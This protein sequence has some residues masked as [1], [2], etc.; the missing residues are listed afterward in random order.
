MLEF[1]SVLRVSVAVLLLRKK[2][3]IVVVQSA[4]LVNL[5]SMVVVLTGGMGCGKSTAGRMFEKRGFRRLDSD[6]IVHDLLESD[7]ATIREVMDVFG[8]KVISSN[9]GVN[10]S[11]LGSIVFDDEE[12]LK[13]LEDIMH[14]KVQE[15]WEV[16]VAS[17]QEAKWILEIPLLFEKNLQNRVDFTIC[18]FSDLKTQV[19]RLEQK[20]IGRVQA[21]A[22]INRQMPLSQKAEDADFVLLNEGSLEFLEDQIKT[23]LTRI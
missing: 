21:L 22:R 18:V 11:L 1:K 20:G 10:R 14:P 2:H 7:P 16:A 5:V 15:A 9:G 3:I 6:Q 19:E 12:K 17:D 13:A 23:L 8:P 4:E